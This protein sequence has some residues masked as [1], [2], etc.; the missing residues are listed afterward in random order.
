V[1]V[2]VKTGS[3]GVGWRPK[4]FTMAFNSGFIGAST[5]TRFS[6]FVTSPS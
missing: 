2:C 5:A 3:S 6:G 1:P 4:D